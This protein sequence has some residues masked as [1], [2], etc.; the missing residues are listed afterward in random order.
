[1]QEQATLQAIGKPTIQPANDTAVASQLAGFT[2]LAPSYLPD[3]YTVDNQPGEWTVSDEI[4]GMMASITYDNQATDDHL[5]IIEKMYR[6][7]EPNT[8]VNRPEIQDVTVRGEPGAWMPTGGGKNSL[9]WEENG[10]TYIIISNTLPKDEVL[11]VAE[12]LGK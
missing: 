11:K 8:V 1:P 10:I 4:N 2:I 3:G 6:Q 7:G 9:A 5:T 12:S